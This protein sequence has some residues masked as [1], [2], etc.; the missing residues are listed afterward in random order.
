[1]TG[2]RVAVLTRDLDHPLLAATRALLA[3]AGHTMV[4]AGPAPDADLLL[5]KARDADALQLARR[6]EESGRP[7]LNSAEA[8]AFCQDRV[9]IEERARAAGIP[10]AATLGTGVL[11]RLPWTA[12]VVVKSRRSR[13]TDLVARVETPDQWAEIA[14]RWP[15]EPVLTQQPVTGD[16]WDRKV[17]VVDGRVFAEQRRSELDPVAPERRPWTPD[18]TETALALAAG[19]AYGLQVYGVDLLP[20]PDG[21][22]AVD[23]NAFPGIRHQPGAPEALAALILRTAR[24]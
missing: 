22:I 19:P 8:T 4:P 16:G 14:A 20:G 24:P 6:Y 7:V 3:A 5:L 2:L 21:P 12:P 1:M 13:K 17:W 9:A 18:P 10:F 15:G 11:G 23:V